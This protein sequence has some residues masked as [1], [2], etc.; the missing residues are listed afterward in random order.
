MHS[1]PIVIDANILVRS[2][3]G[4]RVRNIIIEHHLAVEFFIPD[5]CVSDARK[6][7]PMLFEKRKLRSDIAIEVLDNILKLLTIVDIDLYE[8]RQSEAEERMK[9]RDIDDWPIVATALT[10]DCPIWTEDKD[11]FGSGIS[12]W[13][14]DRIYLFLEK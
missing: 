3:L 1:R 8:Q 5:V 7:L 6:Y 10:L 9:N 11:F 12:T 14:T 2:V 4:E 13:T